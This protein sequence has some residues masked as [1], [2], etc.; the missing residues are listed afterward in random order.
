MPS[1]L[2]D[3]CT[4]LQLKII[5][6]LLGENS[7]EGRKTKHDSN[8]SSWSCTSSY[9]RDLLA[10]YIFKTIK[11]RNSHQ[12]GSSVLELAKSRYSELVKEV[13]FVGSAPGNAHSA[14]EAY[15]DTAAIFPESVHTVV[16]DLQVFP[17][18]ETLSINFNYQF[19]DWSE[20]RRRW[21]AIDECETD[22]DVKRAEEEI[23][24]RALMA[25]TYEAMIRNK[26]IK[27]KNL[28]IR[29]LMPMK[30]STFTNPAFGAFLSRLERF[31]LLIYGEEYN[32]Y[33]TRRSNACYASMMAKLDEYFFNHLTSATAFALKASEHCPLGLK[34]NRGSYIPV[35]FY[36]CQ[37]PLLQELDLEYIFVCPELMYFL[38]D[39][40]PTI[41]H[42]SMYNCSSSIGGFAENEM[43]WCQFFDALTD[44]NPERLSHLQITDKNKDARFGIPLTAEEVYDDDEIRPECYPNEPHE[45]I[46]E[47]F[48]ILEAEHDQRLFAHTYFEIKYGTLLHDLAENLASFQRG[49]DQASYE[50]LMRIVNANAT[51]GGRR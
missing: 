26:A 42:L 27:L 17:N 24:W 28:E 15:R 25:K 48:G 14:D 47:A 31:N 23:A 33:D 30:I 35:A 50:R 43:H 4:E 45:E 10:P 18:L 29:E 7:N 49:E 11:L 1:S 20:W 16:S 19:N 6:K 22:K 21:R 41:E 39:H 13:H 3:L 2:G 12:S 5:E 9:F 8:L 32:K 36:D 51:R 40:V 37:M 46:E 44:A 38:L 34:G